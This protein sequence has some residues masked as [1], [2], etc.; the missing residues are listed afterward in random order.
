MIIHDAHTHIF[1]DKIAAKATKS[2]GDFY[3]FDKM[4][5]DATTENLNKTDEKIHAGFKLV[6]SSAVT[7]EQVDGINTFIVSE[8]S[9]NPS[10]L[11][12]AAL[13][14][15]TKN[16][17]EVLDYAQEHGLRGVKFHSDFQ[18]CNIDD[19]RAYPMYKEMVKRNMPVLFHMGDHRYDF[20]SPL[21]LKKLMHDIPDLKIMAAH[22]GGYHRWDDALTL[23]K[24]KNLYFD[25]SSALPFMEKEIV[26]KFF[27]KFGDDSFLFGTDFPMWNAEEELERFLSLNLGEETNEKVLHKNFE[28]LFGLTYE[29]ENK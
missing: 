7:K 13:H 12:F 22:F 8:C 16:Y 23:E 15:E 25:T 9:K 24:S 21:R 3:E 29:G 11:G 6:C 5:C 26:Y 4:Y 28:K 17:I 1:P 27:E 19:K 20:S 18:R 14:P 10:F 2:I